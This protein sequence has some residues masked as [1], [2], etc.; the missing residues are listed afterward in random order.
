MSPRS[1]RGLLKSQFPSLRWQLTQLQELA[2]LPTEQREAVGAYAN[3]DSDK[4]NNE[5]LAQ[6]DQ[7][8][9]FNQIIEHLTPLDHDIVVWRYIRAYELGGGRK[10]PAYL[11]PASGEYEYVI[12]YHGYRY[13]VLALMRITVPKGTKCLYVPSSVGRIE[14]EILLPHRTR[15]RVDGK[16]QQSFVCSR[17]WQGVAT[18][19]EFTVYSCTVVR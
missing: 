12:T 11:P 3:H 18:S 13:E 5:L 9:L 10:N 19:K 8:P 7:V 14:Y 17:D 6:P 16:E 2:A 1:L 15:L 4:I